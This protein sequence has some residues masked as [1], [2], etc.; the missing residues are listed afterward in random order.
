MWAVVVVARLGL[1]LLLDDA[2]NLPAPI[3][4]AV[5]ARRE[6]ILFGHVLTVSTSRRAESNRQGKGVSCALQNRD[7]LRRESPFSQSGRSVLCS[8]DGAPKALN[9]IDSINFRIIMGQ[10]F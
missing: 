3:V 2:T 6:R 10:H 5:A 9:P 4:L 1:K 8:C 7:H